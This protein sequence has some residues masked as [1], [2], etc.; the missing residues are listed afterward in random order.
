V[1]RLPRAAAATA[2]PPPVAAPELDDAALVA[3]C[4]SG[5]EAAWTE[6]V[7][8]F[9]R[10][11]LAIAAGAYRLPPPDAE[12]A[13]QEVFALT[14]V[15]LHELRRDTAFR[16]WLA[17]LTRRICGQIAQRR[18]QQAL[19]EPPSDR[20][21]PDDAI[22]ELEVALDVQRALRRLPADCGAVLDRFF[23]QDQSYATIGDELG[24][25]AGTIASRIS[26]CL[27]RLRDVAAETGREDRD[28]RPPLER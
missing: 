2:P 20:P 25:P 15:H 9:S 7:R 21:D 14:Y 3:R 11:V 26:R 16:P 4:R 27:R 28:R 18:G 12:D 10:Y 6:L 8:R 17:Q 24:L 23:C 13:F 22:G 19:V 5:D 1:S